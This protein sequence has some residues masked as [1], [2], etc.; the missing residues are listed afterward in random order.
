M[1]SVGNRID[2]INIILSDWLCSKCCEEK[3]KSLLIVLI[4]ELKKFFVS[5]LRLSWYKVL[6]VVM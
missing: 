6:E 3:D 4:R 1:F 2:G 5:R